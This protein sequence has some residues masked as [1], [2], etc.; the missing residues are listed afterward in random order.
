MQPKIELTYYKNGNLEFKNIM[1]NGKKHGMQEWYYDNGILFGKV[2]LLNG[3]RQGILQFYDRK[4][5]KTQFDMNKNNQ[6]HGV[7]VEFIY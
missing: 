3:I 2:F 5:R 1:L 6:T 4:G 7:K